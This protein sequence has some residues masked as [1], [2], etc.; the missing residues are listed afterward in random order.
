MCYFVFVGVDSAFRKRAEDLGQAGVEVRD[1]EAP[2]VNALFS[3]RDAVVSVTRGGCSCGIQGSGVQKFDQERERRK[4]EKKGWSNTKIERALAGRR[5]GDHPEFVRFRDALAELVREIGSVRIFA[6]W[7]S[8]DV[9][10]EPVPRR[11]AKRISLDQYLAA[12]GAY[13]DDAVVEILAKDGQAGEV[14][15]TGAGIK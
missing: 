13:D 11:P 1:S 2:V 8:G 14:R 5:R 4:Y 6:H 9:L 7:F 3:T 15:D 10:T 12:H